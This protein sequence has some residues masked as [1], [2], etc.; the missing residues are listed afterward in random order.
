MS[1]RTH[2]EDESPLCLPCLPQ[3]PDGAMIRDISIDTS[4][5]SNQDNESSTKG[6]DTSQQCATEGCK[7]KLGVGCFYRMC[8]TCCYMLGMGSLPKLIHIHTCLHKIHL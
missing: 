2:V 3:L 6:D 5:S 1:R 7:R 4:T 8:F